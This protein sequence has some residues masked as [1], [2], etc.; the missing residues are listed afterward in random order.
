[1][2]PPIR[3]E[4]VTKHFRRRGA[5]HDYATLKAILSRAE[6]R[7]R[8]PFQA[9]QPLSF[10]VAAGETFALIG[11]NGAGKSTVLKLAA[12][13]Y[14]P[15]AGTVS[16]S[17][18][19]GSLIEL[20][21]GFHPEFSGRENIVISGLLHGLTRREVEARFEDI[22]AF[23]NLG[24]FIEEPVR[25]YSSGMYMRLGFS[26]AIHSDPNILLIDEV[27]AVGDAAF[28]HQCVERLLRLRAGGTTILMATHYLD[29][30]RDLCGRAMWLEQ[31]RIRGLGN[32]SEVCA[33]YEEAVA[34]A[35]EKRTGS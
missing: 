4:Q 26:I 21:L 5:A 11:P 30:V 16:V 12:G 6:K 31:G 29:I 2:A 23:A 33:D 28:Q 9:L 22:V 35:E 34:K 20:G 17:G 19:I 25:T 8:S 13:I 24:D 32:A 14:Q 10:D 27:L 3:F 1:M 18:R 15:D 7:R